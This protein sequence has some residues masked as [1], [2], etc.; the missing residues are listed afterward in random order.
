M[1]AIVCIGQDFHSVIHQNQPLAYG[2]KMFSNIE[3]ASSVWK[4][5]LEG[6]GTGKE[7]AELLDELRAVINEEVS[8]PTGEA[9]VL[10][11]SWALKVLARKKTW[12]H[13]EGP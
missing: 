12:V 1:P 13:L 2:E 7:N 8:P 11:T 6:N 3:E 4:S 5:L 10:D 9:W